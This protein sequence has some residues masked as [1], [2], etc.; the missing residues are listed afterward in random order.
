[1]SKSIHQ[2]VLADLPYLSAMESTCTTWTSWNYFSLTF[3]CVLTPRC[4]V[5]LPFHRLTHFLHVSLHITLSRH[6]HMSVLEH[7]WDLKHDQ[8]CRLST[9]HFKPCF[10]SLLWDEVLTA[11]TGTLTGNILESLFEMQVEKSR[12]H[13]ATRNTTVADWS[14]WSKDIS[15]RKWRIKAWTRDKDRRALGALCKGKA[16]GKGRSNAE[17]ISREEVVH[18]GLQ[19]PML[20]W[21]FVRVHAWP[22]QLRQREWTTSFTFSDSFTA[23]KFERRWK[24]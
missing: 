17:T 5:G 23:P 8:Q 14:S 6:Q 15:S 3:L 16:T 11:A 18:V 7:G 24:R 13:S 10:S 12:R 20:V 9:S 1:M 4:L 19:R 2:V 22:E 21:R